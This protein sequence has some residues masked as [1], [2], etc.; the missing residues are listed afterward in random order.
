MQPAFAIVAD[1]QWQIYR[2]DPTPTL[3]K[4]LRDRYMQ[5]GHTHIINRL[6]K[7]IGNQHLVGIA[8]RGYSK[9][10]LCP[11]EVMII[12]TFNNKDAKKVDS[13]NLLG[14]CKYAID[15]LRRSGVILDD[16]SSKTLFSFYQIQ[17]PVTRDSET[18]LLVREWDGCVPHQEKIKE[19]VESLVE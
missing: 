6:I 12:R 11:A 1:K 19:L 5:Y 13:D 3:N 9:Q 16:D 8:N 10:P 4:M 7:Q 14:G 2:I 18:I 17:V 15:A